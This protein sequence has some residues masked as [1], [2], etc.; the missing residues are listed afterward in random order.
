MKTLIIY[1]SVFGNTAQVAEA[2]GAALG[3]DA[4]VFKV[5][6]ATL[7]TLQSADLL[8]VGS[9]TRAFKPTEGVVN[10]LKALPKEGLA[11]KHCAA[12]DTR[13]PPESIESKFFRTIVVTAGFADKKIANLLQKKGA[14]LLGSEGFF[15]QASEGPLVVGEA[16]R[17]STWIKEVAGKGSI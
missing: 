11:G 15:V 4:Q 3:A 6:D 5:T 7:E 16:E 10:F 1:D 2:M 13:I 14:A 9:P 8:V 12:F 17:A